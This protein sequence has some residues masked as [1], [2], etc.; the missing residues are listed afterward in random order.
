MSIGPQTGTI[1]S[2]PTLHQ[3]SSNESDMEIHVRVREVLASLLFEQDGG[4]LQIWQGS[5][6]ER[7]AAR[8]RAETLMREAERCG[9]EIRPA[10][11]KAAETAVSERL[12][13]LVTI[14]AREAYAL[15]YEAEN[16]TDDVEVLGPPP[17]P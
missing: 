12:T 13:A 8:S 16:L 15:D 7:F 9:L 5:P 3:K 14:P 2:A 10:K 1:S 6:T 11:G 17:P 4:S